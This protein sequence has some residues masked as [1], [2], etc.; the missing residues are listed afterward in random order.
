M[1][2]LAFIAAVQPDYPLLHSIPKKVRQAPFPEELPINKDIV[3]ETLCCY[4]EWKIAQ[5][6]GLARGCSGK[7]LQSISP[8]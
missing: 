1:R 8:D 3:V 7:A 5:C 4:D 6:T 2:N